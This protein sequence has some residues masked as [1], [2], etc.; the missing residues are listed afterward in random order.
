MMF[1][2]MAVSCQ[3]FSLGHILIDY[4]FGAAIAIAHGN[5]DGKDGRNGVRRATN[6]GGYCATKTIPPNFKKR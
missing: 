5:G 3:T 6:S 1:N 2:L 4:V